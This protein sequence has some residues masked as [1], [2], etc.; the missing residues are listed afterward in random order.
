MEVRMRKASRFARRS[1][2]AVVEH[3]EGRRLLAQFNAGVSPDV[4]FVT[5]NAS[6]VPNDNI[7]DTAGIQAMSRGMHLIPT[8]NFISKVKA[9]AASSYAW[10]TAPPGSTPPRRPRKCSVSS[11]TITTTSATASKT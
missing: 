11:P 6:V 7:D 4:V 1:T 10:P 3:M 8:P 5:S 9:R 2:S